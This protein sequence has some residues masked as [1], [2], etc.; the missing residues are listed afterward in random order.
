[1]DRVLSLAETREKGRKSVTHNQIEMYRRVTRCLRSKLG[2]LGEG[3]EL[4]R[5][6]WGKSCRL[7]SWLQLLLENFFSSSN[8]LK[9]KNKNVLPKFRFLDISPLV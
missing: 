8:F 7:Y 6:V 1:M 5:N 3:N 9:V 2:I 4:E